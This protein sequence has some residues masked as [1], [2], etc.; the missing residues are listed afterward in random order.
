MRIITRLL[1]AFLQLI[2]SLFPCSAKREVGGYAFANS[3]VI[4]GSEP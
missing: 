4:N 1:L 2:L 3:S